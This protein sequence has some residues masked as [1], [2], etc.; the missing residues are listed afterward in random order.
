MAKIPTAV[1]EPDTIGGL[2]KAIQKTRDW[3]N[4]KLDLGDAGVLTH[5]GNGVRGNVWMNYVRIDLNNVNQL[6]A[7]ANSPILFEH[8]LSIPRADGAVFG[9][10]DHDVINV[11]WFPV[12]IVYHTDGVPVTPANNRSVTVIYV[13]G[14]S[15]GPDS[16]E[17]TVY[18]DLPLGGGGP[19]D[20]HLHLYMAFFPSSP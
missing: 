19:N 16:I 12:R 7:G 4:Y 13:D 3:L 10:G 8:N 20:K 2:A 1:Q 17:L 15:F 11:C 5:G 14:D 18:T 6:G 9:A